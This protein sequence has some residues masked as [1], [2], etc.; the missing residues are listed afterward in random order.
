MSLRHL[1]EQQKEYEEANALRVQIFSRVKLRHEMTGEKAYQIMKELSDECLSE[2]RD[3]LKAVLA[4]E[5][6]MRQRILK[7]ASVEKALSE[8]QIEETKVFLAP[9][10]LAELEIVEDEIFDPDKQ[11]TAEIFDTKKGISEEEVAW[12]EE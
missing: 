2:L 9:L 11:V 6:E 10:T 12:S 3:D 1:D 5:E 4:A 8:E 7:R